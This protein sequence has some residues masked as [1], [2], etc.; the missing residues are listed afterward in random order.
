[1]N[2]NAE[3]VSKAFSFFPNSQVPLDWIERQQFLLSKGYNAPRGSHQVNHAEA[4]FEPIN[5]QLYGEDKM[6]PY[7][8]KYIEDH[9]EDFFLNED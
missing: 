9:S 1:M 5:Q 6:F 8:K 4:F 7:Y 3:L 2:R